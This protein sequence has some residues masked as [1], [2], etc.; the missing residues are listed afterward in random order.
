MDGKFQIQRWSGFGPS[1]QLYLHSHLGQSLVITNYCNLVVISNFIILMFHHQHIVTVW[2]YLHPN[3]QRGKG[4]QTAVCAP[5]THPP[6]QSFKVFIAQIWRY[7]QHGPVPG[8]GGRVGCGGP[9]QHKSTPEKDVAIT[10]KNRKGW[11]I[12]IRFFLLCFLG[13]DPKMK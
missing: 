5:S 9:N 3:L 4:P 8:G 1:W 11:N 13:S 7:I 6:L 2:L 10:R 12:L